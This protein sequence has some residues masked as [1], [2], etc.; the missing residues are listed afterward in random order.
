MLEPRRLATRAAAHRMAHLRGER[1]GETIGYRM[2]R[3]TRVGP[4]T[5]IEVVTEGVLTR[6]LNSDPTLEGI[7]VLIFDEFHERSIHADLGL[8]LALHSQRLVRDDLRIVVMSATLDGAIVAELLGG[9]AVMAAEGR[10]FPVDIRYRPTKQGQRLEASVASAVRTALAETDGDVLVFLPGQGEIAR[11][12]AALTGLGAAIEVMPLYGNLSFA[13]QDR[14]I[15]PSPPGRRKVVL[16][17]SIAETSLTIEGVRA[18]VDAGLAR[19]PRFSPRT[20]MTSLTTVR[21]SRAAADQRAGRAG[22]VAPGICYR[23]WNADEHAHLLPFATPEILEADLAPLALDL[24]AAGITDPQELRWLTPPPR[25]PWRQAVE[26]LTWLEALDSDGKATTHGRAMAALG[27][28]PR[29]AHMMLRAH[30]SG[31]GALACDIAAILEERDMLRS[32]GDEHDADLRLRAELV[33]GVRLRDRLPD[34]VAGM[35]VMRDAVGRVSESARAWRRDLG[36]GGA[37]E[38]EEASAA[39]R[40]VALAFPDRVAQRRPGPLP[41]YQLRYGTGSVLTDSPGIASEPYLVIAETDGKVPESRVFL[42][43]PLT[44]EELRADFASQI[45][46][47]KVLEWDTEHGLR[48]VEREVLGA[49]VLQERRA[50]APDPEAIRL[51]ALKAITSSNLELLTWS[52]AARRLRERL[53]FIH[54]HDHTW[55]DVSDGALIAEAEHWLAPHLGAIRSRGDLERLDL[56]AFLLDRLDWRQRSLLDELAPT[57]FTA[58]T[59]SRLPIDYS[60]PGAPVVRVRLQEMFGQ[61]ATPRVMGGRIPLTLHLLSPAHRPVQVTQNLESFWKSSYFDVRKD[62][63]GRYPKHPWP[64]DPLSATPTR[65]RK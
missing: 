52:D 47:E 31:D 6:M 16:S 28:H 39:G 45:T 13:D 56:G 62:M 30:A 51:V 44:L 27:A 65:R 4:R 41:R 14:A 58:P 1:I 53:A 60:E 36:V 63:K 59:G 32:G 23:L 34:H 12:D 61:V 49:L 40:L 25:G 21:V 35:R 37:H 55:P 15:A 50:R 43:A 3:D 19:I 46:T 20:G 5:R 48:A 64:E 33:R 18:V 38:W 54:H 57:H 7:G 17:T 11:C 10:V 29:I 42:A 24:A 8:A 9:A 2:R 22:R 26:L